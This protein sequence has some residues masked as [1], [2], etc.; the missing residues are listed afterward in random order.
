MGFPKSYAQLF[1]FGLIKSSILFGSSEQQ[2]I[3]EFN[4]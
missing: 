2:I 1:R 3:T 4:W